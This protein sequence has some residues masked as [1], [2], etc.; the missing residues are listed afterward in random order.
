MALVLEEVFLV[1]EESQTLVIPILVG[2]ILEDLV[3]VSHMALALEEAFLVFK[4]SQALV[5]PILEGLIQRD[6]M[7][8]VLE[9]IILILEES[10]T[11][12]DLI[13]LD[14]M[15]LVLEVSQT[16]IGRSTKLQSII[17]K[18]M[19]GQMANLHN[20]NNIIVLAI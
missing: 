13:L 6:L 2:L 17:P 7:V 9:E 14:H 16:P 18:P 19:M 3:L 5:G 11:L 15:V 12:V 20:E 8:L 10:Q 1:L 4:E